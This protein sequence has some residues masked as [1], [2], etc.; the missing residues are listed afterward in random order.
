MG[1][2]DYFPANISTAFNN[3]EPAHSV[4]RRQ[5]SMAA[6]AHQVLNDLAKFKN[7]L[8][9]Y[10]D[11]S[12]K[13][14]AETFYGVFDTT[15]REKELAKLREELSLYNEGEKRR[16]LELM[17]VYSGLF[18]KYAPIFV[19]H[20]ETGYREAFLTGFTE[21]MVSKNVTDPMYHLISELHSASKED[22]ELKTLPESVNKYF[23]ELLTDYNLLV[24]AGSFT[25]EEVTDEILHFLTDYTG[26]FADGQM[27]TEFLRYVRN[28]N[29]RCFM[30][31]E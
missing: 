7:G 26:D 29:V 16:Q 5:D 21:K 24:E 3:D 31:E 13:E 17:V 11:M 12:E 14:R 1:I 27:H 22:V 23:L 6:F 25:P 2:F 8:D 10:M 9:C 18:D 30:Q 4:L 20:I 19:D 15:K 28:L